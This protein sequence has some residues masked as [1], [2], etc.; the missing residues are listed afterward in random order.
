M[1]LRLNNV[2]V[3]LRDQLLIPPLDLTVKPGEI[4]TIMGPS[5]SGKSTLLAFIGGT[6]GPPFEAAGHV[7][8]GDT[9]IT[10]LPPER[11]RIGMLFQDDL[12][13][14]H[15]SVGGNI[16]FGIPSALRG[17][18]RQQRID[19][20]LADSGLAGFAHRDPAS[21]SGGQRARVA[22]LR[23]LLS[24]PEGLLLDEPFGKLDTALREGFRRFV[25][26]RAKA[27]SLPVLL[28][29]H[30]CSDAEAAGGRILEMDQLGKP[31]VNETVVPIAHG[32]APIP[33]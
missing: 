12:L 23:T 29:T 18:Q 6:I 19:D 3:R 28:V 24:E 17:K 8:C 31:V 26:S 14:P 10:H 20:A 33:S 5:G 13:F 27:H 2:S 15:L 9:E 7:Y 32:L 4:V 22:L 25:F 21:L 1:A 16:A 11:R 30:D